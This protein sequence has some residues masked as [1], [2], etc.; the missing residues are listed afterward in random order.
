MK[1]TWR[2]T[3]A[4]IR[5]L[6]VVVGITEL[7][8]NW[9][10]PNLSPVCV[11]VCVLSPGRMLPEAGWSRVE[12]ESDPP[13][14]C[15]SEDGP[16]A[17][18][19]SGGTGTPAPGNFT[20][21]YILKPS[22]LFSLFFPLPPRTVCSA[23][24]RWSAFWAR[25]C[26]CRRTWSWSSCWTRVCSRSARPAERA[27]CPDPASWPGPPYGAWLRNTHRHTHTHTHTHTHR[28]VVGGQ[29]NRFAKEYK[30]FQ[31]DGRTNWSL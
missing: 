19:P 18:R 16:A 21:F 4:V 1:W 7:L 23:S 15:V 10:N 25:T 5:I 22:H 29:H 12:V 27:S 26:C 31:Y 30:A 13:G 9:L 20:C 24:T 11:C 17:G 8:L 28:C 6:L 2:S 14:G 3:G